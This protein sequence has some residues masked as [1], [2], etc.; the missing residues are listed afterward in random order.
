MKE[1]FDLTLGYT[2]RV[3]GWKDLDNYSTTV[4]D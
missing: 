4:L 3:K 2:G 1:K